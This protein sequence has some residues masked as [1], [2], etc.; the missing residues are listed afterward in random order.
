MIHRE[1]IKL[2]FLIVYQSLKVPIKVVQLKPS[3]LS[4]FEEL[5]TND[6]RKVF[7][8]F[9]AEASQKSRQVDGMRLPYR[10]R[11]DRQ[12]Y[13]FFSLSPVCL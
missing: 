5:V 4:M 11:T 10:H 13:P 12:T 7:F 6:A 9:F 2:N 8:F 1:L 3:A